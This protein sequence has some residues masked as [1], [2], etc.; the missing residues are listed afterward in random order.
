MKF[1]EK[2]ISAF[3]VAI[4]IFLD[5]IAVIIAEL[6]AIFLRNILMENNILQI[7]ELNMYIAI[8]GIY[9]LFFN[10]KH[11]Y[12]T[13][14]V[15]YKTLE[16]IIY[17][18]IYA[19]GTIIV[20]LYLEQN[21][22]EMSRLFI[23]LFWLFSV[24]LLIT[25]RYIEKFFF[26][27]ARLFQESVLIVG[28][29]KT[30]V[31]Y[32]NRIMSDAGMN[33][34]V[35]GLLED[36]EIISGLENIPVLGGFADAAKVI[37]KYGINS[38]VIAAPGLSQ[39]KLA[40]LILSIHPLV[41]KLS[42]IPNLVGVP[43][44]NIGISSFYDEKIILINLYN[45]LEKI[46]NRSIKRILD[47]VLSI[48]GILILSPLLGVLAV[49]IHLDSSGP[50]IYSGKRLGLNGRLFKCYK[51]RTMYINSDKILE[52]YLDA[53]PD[54]KKNYKVYHKINDDPRCTHVGKALRKLSLDELPQLFNV[55]QGEMS[56]V[57]PRP[58]LLSEKKDM[59]KAQN[60][61]LMTRPGIT[62]LWQVSG[63]S[64]V[65]FD[66]RLEM[67]MWYVRNWSVW[68]DIILLFKTIKVVVLKKGA[69]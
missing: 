11:L 52:S 56:L 31:L 24:F 4:Y 55:L 6:L 57:G 47:I 28:G 16:N 60:I 2:M 21:I 32:Y 50:I 58:Y 12:N 67:D 65:T 13:N 62:G 35:V 61:I 64:E 23:L 44:S 25:I 39:Q 26:K 20:L 19:V 42:I 29:G 49:C 54:K 1:F 40:D 38:V 66:E 41:K 34:R 14:E 33:I 68:I 46:I 5:Y 9:I 43:M 63:R 37:T 59:H 51:F 22:N 7:Y 10:I 69:Y 36:Y 3:S 27:N 15:F 17:A 48:A 18:S 45:N 8:P 30:A 53:H